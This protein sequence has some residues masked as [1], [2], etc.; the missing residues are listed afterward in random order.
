FNNP[1]WSEPFP[2]PNFTTDIYLDESDP[3]NGCVYAIPGHHMVGHVELKGKTQ[4]ELFRDCGAVPVVMEPG[5][6]LFHF[7]ST[8]HG[9]GPN[10]SDRQRRVFYIHYMSKK[11]K[12]AFYPQWNMAADSEGLAF[13][14][15]MAAARE[16]LGLGRP[17]DA[18]TIALDETGVRFTGSP[19]SAPDVWA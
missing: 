19:V 4:E 3:D 2:A 15:R 16:R 17:D 6:V 10:R 9:S 8:P 13:L 5:D 12:D 7:I 1:D 14:E 11:V 18:G